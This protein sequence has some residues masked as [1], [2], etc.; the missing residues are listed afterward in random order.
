LRILDNLI[1]DF[2]WGPFSAFGNLIEDHFWVIFI[3]VMC[4]G[5]LLPLAALGSVAMSAG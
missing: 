3:A 2:F 4:V 5:P 1:S